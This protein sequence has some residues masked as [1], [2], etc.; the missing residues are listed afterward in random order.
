MNAQTLCSSDSQS[1]ESIS[2]VLSG[3]TGVID[4][5]G[6]EYLVMSNYNYIK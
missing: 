5:G 3:T 4:A 2:T 1:E 6:V